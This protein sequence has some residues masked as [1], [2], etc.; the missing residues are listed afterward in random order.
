M[1][2]TQTAD[3]D[4]EA[5]SILKYY[6][7]D[8]DIDLELILME[9]ASMSAETRDIRARYLAGEDVNFQ[10][11]LNFRTWHT[12][13]MWS[14]DDIYSLYYSTTS[15]N[16]WYMEDPEID[17]L[18]E[19]CIS[20]LPMEERLEANYECQDIWMQNCYGIPLY[21]SPYIYTTVPEFGGM[22]VEPN[23]YPWLG[24]AYLT[25]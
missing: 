7:A 5:A 8:V 2:V 23:V 4:I 20:D 13:T 19:I 16:R 24:Q 11:H 12:D 6:F 18:A 10:F 9:S 22:I 15:S 14:G 21:T 25:P 1:Y 17:R 3:R